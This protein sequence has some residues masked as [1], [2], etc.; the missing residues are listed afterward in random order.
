MDVETKLNIEHWQLKLEDEIKYITSIENNY[1]YILTQKNF[2]VYSKIKDKETLLK[3]PIPENPDIDPNNNNKNND[4]INNRIWPDK[5]GTH[6][7][8]KLDS[9]CYYYNSNFQEKK[10]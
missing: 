8:F 9:V 3:Y 2:L 1:T 5:F 4:F 7:I 10:K 6:I